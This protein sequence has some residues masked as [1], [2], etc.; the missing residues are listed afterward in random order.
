[1]LCDK[2]E[3]NEGIE[4][5]Y[6]RAKKTGQTAIPIDTN[7]QNVTTRYKFDTIV[8]SMTL[9]ERCVK[10]RYLVTTGLRLF[11]LLIA[12]RKSHQP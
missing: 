10:K 2:C 3:Q 7:R 8:K 5:K 1:M 9:C 11:A 6:Y 12:H 4:Y